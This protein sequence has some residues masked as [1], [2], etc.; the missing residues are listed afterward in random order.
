[1]Y[2]STRRQNARAESTFHENSPNMWVGTVDPV[3]F[4]HGAADKVTPCGFR[5]LFRKAH[6][7]LDMDGN[8]PGP[9][10]EQWLA[11]KTG[12]V[13]HTGTS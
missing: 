7:N 6:D 8:R 12:S 10:S 4:H 9:P 13:W 1:M 5:S 2:A 11:S 3:A